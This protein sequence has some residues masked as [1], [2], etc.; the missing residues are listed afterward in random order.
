VI[1]YTGAIESFGQMIIY[2]NSISFY[3]FINLLFYGLVYFFY[4][5]SS[6]DILSIT[7][8]LDARVKVSD[9]LSLIPFAIQQII[10]LGFYAT[11]FSLWMATVH[12]PCCIEIVPF[13]H[14]FYAKDLS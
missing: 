7:D 3:L 14:V 1:L 12:R 4:T 2:K 9:F 5:Q 10:S 6:Y 11:Y 13:V 8:S